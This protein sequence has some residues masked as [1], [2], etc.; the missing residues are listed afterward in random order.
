M[1]PWASRRTEIRSRSPNA[2]APASPRPGKGRSFL[3]EAAIAGGALE[4]RQELLEARLGAQRVE[5]AV[6][7]Q[8]PSRREAL[9]HSQL[10]RAQCV[11]APPGA[12]VDAGEVDE[13][14]GP[15]VGDLRRMHARIDRAGD[16]SRLRQRHRQAVP[17]EAVLGIL[18]DECAPCLGRLEPVALVT[19]E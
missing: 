3:A 14:A 12:R 18:R 19:E 10:E 9:A 17:G 8:P 7:L 5:V 4:P 15:P 16:I 2:W 11:V 6:V 1:S 13:R